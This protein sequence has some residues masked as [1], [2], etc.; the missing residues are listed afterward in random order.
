MCARDKVRKSER[1]GER[2]STKLI[3]RKDKQRE[4]IAG[5]TVR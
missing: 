4:G 5:Q 1:V 3:E 2:E